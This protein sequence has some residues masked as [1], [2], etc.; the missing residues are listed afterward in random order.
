MSGASSSSNEAG[1]LISASLDH[2]SKDS[3]SAAQAPCQARA[4]GAATPRSSASASTIAW[5]PIPRLGR[6]AKAG[7]VGS[8]LPAIFTMHEDAIVVR[9][10]DFPTLLQCETFDAALKEFGALQRAAD[11][12]RERYYDSSSDSSESMELHTAVCSR[13]L[14]HEGE[15]VTALP[16]M[17]E[18]SDLV[19][20]MAAKCHKWTGECE[21]ASRLPPEV[22]ASSSST[23]C[24]AVAASSTSEQANARAKA[25]PSA[26][27]ACSK[28]TGS[29]APPYK[30]PDIYSTRAHLRPD[31]DKE[32]ENNRYASFCSDKEAAE[33][34]LADAE[35]LHQLSLDVAT[36]V[37]RA[38]ARYTTAIEKMHEYHGKLQHRHN[39]NHYLWQDADEDSPL[40]LNFEADRAAQCLQASLPQ[41]QFEI[42]AV[43]GDVI[44]RRS[45]TRLFSVILHEHEENYDLLGEDF[46][47]E[48][49]D[50]EAGVGILSPVK[51]VADV[52]ARA[53]WLG[54][55]ERAIE[56]ALAQRSKLVEHFGVF[57]GDGALFADIGMF[58]EDG[59]VV[60]APA[61]LSTSSRSGDRD[62][63][64]EVNYLSQD[65]VL[66]GFASQGLSFPFALKTRHR[67]GYSLAVV[68]GNGRD[69]VRWTTAA[70]AENEK[71]QTRTASL[72]S[73]SLSFAFKVHPLTGDIFSAGLVDTRRGELEPQEH[74]LLR[75]STSIDGKRI[76]MQFSTIED[77]H[78]L[79]FRRNMFDAGKT[80]RGGSTANTSASDNEVKQDHEQG[81][82]S[83][84]VKIIEA[85][86]EQWEQEEH[87]AE[88]KVL[89]L[90]GD[91]GL[92][93]DT[94]SGSLVTARASTVRLRCAFR[95]YAAF[96]VVETES[97]PAVQVGGRRWRLQCE[98]AELCL[99]FETQA[100]ADRFAAEFRLMK[101]MTADRKFF[102]EM[103]ALFQNLN[104]WALPL[105]KVMFPTAIDYSNVG[106]PQLL[107]EENLH[108]LWYRH[109]DFCTPELYVPE[110]GEESTE[111]GRRAE[112]LQT[113]RF[114]EATWLDL[115]RSVLMNRVKNPSPD[116]NLRDPISFHLVWPGPGRLRADVARARA[117]GGAG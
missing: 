7:D 57:Q 117:G 26:S 77:V 103:P 87:D 61:F 74:Q 1:D 98:Y 38:R 111:V 99:H 2:S 109:V 28:S 54:M 60:A 96:E 37:F 41:I 59:A 35:A 40:G 80:S 34:M 105:I 97:S 75:R 115:A 24:T 56:F 64:A 19:H 25:S 16:R 86:E 116:I 5:P 112:Q 43:N 29:P 73:L 89:G 110:A 91:L 8:V 100:E 14:L 58:D 93:V 107:D 22:E 48:V 69:V 65:G 13:F 62:K 50:D 36:H 6:L 70:L 18:L 42:T 23:A 79:F 90:G 106:T 81:D 66:G 55:K 47:A 31:V 92:G 53:V 11:A 15:C 44:A 108:R 88:T 3:A 114:G 45:A 20:E 30:R 67:F 27:P 83:G 82:E 9:R 10:G 94:S 113:P 32:E 12:D 72:G 63:V 39:E 46:D 21:A 84:E 102:G 104:P 51:V 68:G 85:G 78:S 17:P 76:R 49:D 33:R 4:R 95:K 52:L 101:R 71:E